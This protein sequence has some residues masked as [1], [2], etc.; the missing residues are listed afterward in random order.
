M[1]VRDNDVTVRGRVRGM[2][3]QLDRSGSVAT[4][5][6]DRADKRNAL[7]GAMMTELAAVLET[8]GADRAVRV[9]VLRGRGTVFT[10][11]I[12]HALLAEVMGAHLLPRG[13]G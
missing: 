5:W 6:L 9:V 2:P 10:S 4:V 3:I 13:V 7:D 1:T 12:D 8:I 11:G